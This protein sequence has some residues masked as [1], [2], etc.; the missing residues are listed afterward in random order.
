MMSAS[1]GVTVSLLP[2][3]WFRVLY[4]VVTKVKTCTV[5]VC[6]K[7]EY[8]KW[9][10]FYLIYFLAIKPWMHFVVTSLREKYQT[11]TLYYTVV[12]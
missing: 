5:V 9:L 11:M 10:L 1:R 3:I 8:A 12:S 6:H 2:D 4:E 7:W